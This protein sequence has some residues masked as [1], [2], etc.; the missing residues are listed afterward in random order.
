MGSW[1]DQYN[2]HPLWAKL[3]TLRERAHEVER[4]DDS[5]EIDSLLYLLAALDNVLSRR[6]RTPPLLVPKPLLESTSVSFDAMSTTFDNWQA[7]SVDFTSM[8]AATGAFL[9][10][11]AAWPSL[12]SDAVAETVVSA[13]ARVNEVSEAAIEA[14]GLKRDQLTTSIDDLETKVVSVTEAVETQQTKLDE[15]LSNFSV[16]SGE[17]L[18]AV[19]EDWT[20][21]RERQTTAA[22]EVLGRLSGLEGEARELV[23]AA[24]S[25]IVA[26]DYG[27]YARNKTIAAWTCDIAAAVIGAAGIGAI[28][29]HLYREG[30]EVDG[31]VG[32]SLTRLAASLGTLGIAALVAHRGHDH[33]VEARAAKRTDLALRQVGPFV[34]NLPP[35]D[36]ER[37][38]VELTDRIFIKGELGESSEGE[39]ETLW[40][41][42][43]AGRERANAAGAES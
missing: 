13:T 6:H 38:V 23:H 8:D 31:N 17:K 42:I 7:G 12:A 10:I 26:T 16:A 18:T 35:D 11:I 9:Q 25:S 24:T 30:V 43:K 34:A 4:S 2:E 1:D 27:R 33:H 39:G 21:E 40:E 41:R 15:A 22:D 19:E 37:I 14:V 28:L 3:A 5:N 29:L 20:A 32:L 36:R